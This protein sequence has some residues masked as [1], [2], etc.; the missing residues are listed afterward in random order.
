MES[1][2]LVERFKNF[3]GIKPERELDLAIEALSKFRAE[4]ARLRA[5]LEKFKRAM[6]EAREAICTH[7]QDV[8]C[9][10]ESCHWW[11]GPQKED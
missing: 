2:K 10:G 6:D 11:G 3:D 7:C 8:P 1:D 5:E 4:N 9:L